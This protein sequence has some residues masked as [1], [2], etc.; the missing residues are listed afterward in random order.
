MLYI[1]Y[2]CIE[3]I[4]QFVTSLLQASSASPVRSRLLS[5]SVLAHCSAL[6]GATSVQLASRVTRDLKTV[7]ADRK[8][9]VR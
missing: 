6:E 7:L 4:L 2:N 8:R 3:S 9:L 1:F 5:L